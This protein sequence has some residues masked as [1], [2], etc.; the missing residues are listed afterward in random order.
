LLE[1]VSLVG[2][3]SC[4]LL[5]VVNKSLVVVV[6]SGCL[7]NTFV[8]WLDEVVS[9]GLENMVLVSAGFWS[10]PLESLVELRAFPNAVDC[11]SVVVLPVCP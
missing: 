3:A 6:V 2:L 4:S 5:A 11:A 8:L 9:A 10:G 7:P 1:V